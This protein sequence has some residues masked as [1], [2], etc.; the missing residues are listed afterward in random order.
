MGL[1]RE[2][3]PST[4]I[5]ELLDL[6][7]A[8]RDAEPLLAEMVHPGS[9]GTSSLDVRDFGAV[10]DSGASRNYV[11]QASLTTAAPQGDEHLKL[12]SN[13]EPPAVPLHTLAT[14][15]PSSSCASLDSFP[16]ENVAELVEE[17]LRDIEELQNRCESATSSEDRLEAQTLLQA[18]R[19]ELRILREYAGLE[20]ASNKKK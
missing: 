8:V 2:G 3:L 5:S 17:K 6:V 4:E 9:N 20:N 13:S 19:E 1:T 7:A 11:R 18:A 16:A 14:G 10:D 12:A 15:S